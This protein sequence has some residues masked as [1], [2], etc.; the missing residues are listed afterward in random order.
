MADNGIQSA[1][2][3]ATPKLDEIIGNASGSTRRQKVEQFAA[4]LA[5]T[6]PLSLLGI[7]APLFALVDDLEASSTTA[8]SAW[9]YADGAA[10]GIY[11]KVA[12]VWTWSLPLPYSFIEAENTGAGTANAIVAT[13]TI[14]VT[15]GPL[16]ILPIVATTTGPSTVSFN[17]AAPIT[18]KTATGNDLPANALVNGMRVMGVRSATEFRLVTEIVSAAIIA[19]AQTAA[20]LALA[21]AQQ[22]TEMAAFFDPDNF[23]LVGELAAIAAAAKNAANIETGTLAD[24][25]LATR[26]QPFGLTITNFNDIA[27]SGWHYIASTGSNLPVAATAFLAEAVAKDAANIMV[28]A[29]SL[30]ADPATIWQRQKVANVWGTWRRVYRTADEVRGIAGEG[31]GSLHVRHQV[32]VNTAG[33]SLVAGGLN[34]RPLNTVVA[35]TI[36]GASLAS[37]QITLPAG[38]YEVNVEAPTYYSNYAYTYLHNVT[39]NARILRGIQNLIAAS[40]YTPGGG[41]N[42]RGT[43]TLAAQKVIEIRHYSSHGRATDGLGTPANAGEPEI[44]AEAIF[45]KIA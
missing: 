17:G 10:S 19:Q 28:T 39:D 33:G 41:G 9:V 14:P 21:R 27:A 31:F 36:A 35:N 22:A 12:G 30:G 43:F 44:Y 2:L 20:D 32:A 25:R 13:T 18:I 6:R 42:L 16:V 15:D 34:T 37:N 7:Q 11:S 40:S 4:Q 45:K 1:N 24:A 5:S 23:A 3:T 26:L 38:T 8:T 29:Y